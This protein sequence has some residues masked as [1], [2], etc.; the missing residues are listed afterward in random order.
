MFYGAKIL[1]GENDTDHTGVGLK[2]YKE[3][4][5]SQRALEIWYVQEVLVDERPALKTLP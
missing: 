5:C 3:S 2:G 4:V 1:E